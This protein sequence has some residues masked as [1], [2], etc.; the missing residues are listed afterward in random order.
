MDDSVLYEDNTIRVD[1]DG[2]TIKRYYFPIGRSK[3]IAFG[4]IRSVE[5]GPAGFATKWRLWGSTNLINWFP[6]DMRRTKKT[7]FVELDLGK[8]IKPSITPDDPVQ[9]AELIRSQT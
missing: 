7:Q 2:L 4:D 9:V 8:R 1:H 6:L 3:R 5:T